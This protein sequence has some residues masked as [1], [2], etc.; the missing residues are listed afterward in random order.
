MFEHAHSMLQFSVVAFT[1]IFF[2]V[3]PFAVIPAFLS[4]TA[5]DSPAQRR[6]S[7]KR[8]AVTCFIVLSLFA[9]AGSFIFRLFGLTLPAFEIAGGL[10]LLLIGLEMLQAKRSGTQESA[11]ETEEG[12][13]KDDPGVLPL[14]IP[15][16]AGPGAISTVMVLMGPDP[17]LQRSIPIFAAIT[18]TSLASFLVLAGADRVRK[19]MGETG[20]RIMMRLMG[21]ILTALAVQFVLN[22]LTHLN[23][24]KPI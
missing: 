10:I 20:I 6:R 14:G 4:M 8:A 5:T 18:V 12:E 23:V 21:L 19:Y 22:G 7:A 17:D 1:S 11:K 2:L 9:L 16:L 3:D 13:Q 15:M 24:L